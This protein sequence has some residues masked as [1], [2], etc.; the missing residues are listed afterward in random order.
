[1]NLLDVIEATEV[2]DDPLEDPEELV[3]LSIANY[4]GFELLVKPDWFELNQYLHVIYLVPTNKRGPGRRGSSYFI[5]F[6][7]EILA[8]GDLVAACLSAAYDIGFLN[9]ELAAEDA[10]HVAFVGVEKFVVSCDFCKA[11][12]TDARNET[13][14]DHV[15]E[16]HRDTLRLTAPEVN[17]TP[18][19]LYRPIGA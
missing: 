2:P 8:E 15:I 7:P 11:E 16:V 4:P 17:F 6:V 10:T 13:L 14:W 12:L 19:S 3:S 5:N 18:N 9:G 1:M